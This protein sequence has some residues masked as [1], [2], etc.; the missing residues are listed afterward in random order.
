MVPI[1]TTHRNSG[2]TRLLGAL[3]APDSST[4]LQAAQAAGT[5]PAPELVGALVQR[6][7]VE[8]DFFVRDMLTWALTRLPA[9]T[10]LP[11]LRAELTS[12]CAQAR[13]QALHTLSKIGDRA[14]WPAIM[15]S[16][17]RDPDDEVARSAWRAAVVLAPE[18][19]KGALAAELATQLGRGDR[20]VQ[21]SLSRA[22]VA[23]GDP[24][25][26]VLDAAVVDT[27]P[28]VRAHASA[29][30]RLL[31]DP[32]AGFDLAVDAARRVVALGPDDPEAAC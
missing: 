8:P 1:N 20:E 24:A 18:Q 9:Q 25:E 6:C 10:T 28:A 7:A 2:H 3:A 30:Q 29:T 26:P 11:E 22:F 5:H 16:L 17:L 12:E 27:N 15:R 23:L 32:E 13:S 14:V 31:C 19:E 21:L 4:R